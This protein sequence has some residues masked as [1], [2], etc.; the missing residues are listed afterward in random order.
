MRGMKIAGNLRIS[1]WPLVYIKNASSI[2]IEDNVTLNSSNLGYHLNMHSRVK[3]Y[4]DGKKA[5]ITIGP[6]TRIHGTCIHAR[7]KITI[8]ANCLIAANCQIFD[9]NGHE[10][11]FENA[12]NRIHTTG[13]SKPVVIED[14]VWIGAH[15]IILPGVHIGRGS[16]IGAGSVVTGSIPAGVTAAGN[17]AK[18]LNT[19]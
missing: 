3:L 2:F 1:G 19:K 13:S 17:P 11:T 10:V 9:N 14:D 5:I 6:N 16:V 4:A 8:G 12:E 7:E 15:A 18:V